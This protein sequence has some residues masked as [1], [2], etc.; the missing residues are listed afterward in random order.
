MM[1]SRRRSAA[2]DGLALRR[3]TYSKSGSNGRPCAGPSARSRGLKPLCAKI[4]I[5]SPASTASNDAG[6]PG[7]LQ[8]DGPTKARALQPLLCQLSPGAGRGEQRQWDR[9]FA[10]K[11]HV[12][13]RRPDAAFAIQH[14]DVFAWPVVVAIGPVRFVDLTVNDCDVEQAES[15]QSGDVAPDAHV[16]FKVDGRIAAIKLGQ[17]RCQRSRIEIFRRSESNKPFGLGMPKPGFDLLLKR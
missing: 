16:D 6:K 10:I 14:P 3:T 17:Q 7:G 8:R 2:N 15:V 11:L 9:P 4:D 13:Q 5:A 1:T 12:P